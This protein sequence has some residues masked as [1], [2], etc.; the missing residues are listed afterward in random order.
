MRKARALKRRVP[1]EMSETEKRYDAYLDSQRLAGQI[2]DC[3]YEPIKLK[4]AKA[5]FYTPDFMV[6]H[7]DGTVEF[8]EVKG[9]WK[10]PHQDKSR[11]KLKV[12][13]KIHHWARFVAVTPIPKKDG[14]GW[15]R[16]VIDPD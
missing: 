8:V 9:S 1:G 11:V 15:K 14:G 5:T 3:G 10:A 7:L 4:L 6:L 12:A 13:A 2:D 16:E